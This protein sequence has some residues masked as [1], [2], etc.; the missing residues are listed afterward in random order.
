MKLL[1]AFGTDDGEILNDDHVGMAKFFYIYDFSDGKAELIEKRKN[2]HFAGEES[3][4]GDPE[5][6]K[7]TSS[8]LKG[9]N[10]LAGKKF[11]PNLTRLLGEFVCVVVRTNILSAAI[12]AV[13]NNIDLIIEQNNK[14]E[15]RRHIVLHP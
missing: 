14:A 11:G 3:M 15:N 12:E 5:K 2:S 6:A 13:Q 10:V 8:V 4:H 9:V 7:V 1:V